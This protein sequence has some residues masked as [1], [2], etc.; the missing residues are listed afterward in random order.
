MELID[1][2]PDH[3][4]WI[5]RAAVPEMYQCFPSAAPLFIGRLR[6]LS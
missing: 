6:I 5:Q 1:E 3:D 4:H 2:L